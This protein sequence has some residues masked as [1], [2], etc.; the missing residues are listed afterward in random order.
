VEDEDG[1]SLAVRN[2]DVDV[3]ML[4]DGIEK[5]Y[6]LPTVFLLWPTGAKTARPAAFKP[7][8]T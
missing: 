3:E 6:S 1:I 7:L 8:S 5:P 2:D 4:T